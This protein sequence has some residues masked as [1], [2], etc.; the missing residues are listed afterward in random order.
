MIYKFLADYA[1]DSSST[2]GPIPSTIPT[3][4]RASTE[5]TVLNDYIHRTTGT[6]CI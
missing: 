6:S 4:F 3:S 1:N 2:A 5:V